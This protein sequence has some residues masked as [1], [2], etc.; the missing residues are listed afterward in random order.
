MSA[1]ALRFLI[2]LLFASLMHLP[3]RLAWAVILV[4][5]A[6]AAGR[7]LYAGNYLPRF[8]MDVLDRL[9]DR[10]RLEADYARL[11]QR[12]AVLD[13]DELAGHIKARLIGQDAVADAV[14]HQIRRRLATRQREKPIAIFC[15]AGPPGVGK[16]YFAKILAEKLYG[17]DKAL[18]FF[19]MSQFGQPH[20][21]ATLFG[22]A[23]GY[24]GSDTY[25]TLTRSL[26]EQPASVVLLDEIEKAHGEVHRRF[27]T[28][29]NDG[30][31]T[32]ASDGAKVPTT[33]AIFI[34]TTN[35]AASAIGD[36]A[37]RFADDPD[38]L[39]AAARQALIE[40]RFAPEMVSRI[41]EVFAFRPLTGLDIARVV[42]LEIERLVGRFELTLADGGIAPEILIDALDRAR[43]HAGSSVRDLARAIERQ[44][45]DGLIDAKA[46]GAMRI[47]LEKDRDGRIR[48]TAA[49]AASGAA[50]DNRREPV[51]AE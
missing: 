27:L 17:S 39:S 29:W 40:A 48:A 35:A 41:D 22:Q 20:A 12:I 6:I 21:A 13:A 49:A 50:A 37:T 7:F 14:A 31:V 36:L 23:R 44:I 16:T 5:A 3:P 1:W 19:D 46:A 25:G 8:V 30:F 33:D 28:A 26:R 45:T 10:A 9:T 34:L 42:A 32:E 51:A 4:A 18:H 43:Q 24:V 47:R 2:L 11:E 38:A 15:F